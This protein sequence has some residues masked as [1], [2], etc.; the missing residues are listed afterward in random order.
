MVSQFGW[1]AAVAVLANATVATLMLGT[2]LR[3]EARE[4][5]T[6]EAPVKKEPEE[7]PE[8]KAAAQ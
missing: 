5:A 3:G 4:A 8:G 7:A 6:Q 1:K 2:H